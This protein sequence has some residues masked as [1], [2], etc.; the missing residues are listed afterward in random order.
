ML[1]R[2]S[3]A[4]GVAALIGE[5]VG[6]EHTTTT[7]PTGPEAKFLSHVAIMHP[8]GISGNTSAVRICTGCPYSSQLRTV[9]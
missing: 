2:T 7:T 6:K 9:G 3:F 1:Q 4:S 5:K 8:P